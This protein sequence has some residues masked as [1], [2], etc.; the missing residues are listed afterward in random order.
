MS[1]LEFV[2]R[3]YSSGESSMKKRNLYVMTLAGLFAIAC[4]SVAA[5]FGGEEDG[6]YAAKLWQQ[7]AAGNLVGKYALYST[8]YKGAFPHGDYLDTIDAY[9]AVGEHQERLLMQR[10]YGG[11]G[12]TKAMV[13]NEPEKYL[14]AVT[15]MYK[16]EKGYDKENQD[17]FWVKYS[18]DGEVLKNP[19]GVVLAG[20]VAKGAKAGCIACHTAAPGGDMV[21]NNDR[22]RE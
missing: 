22:V 19:E 3:K 8:P 20:R 9:L 2:S 5:P 15:V 14:K 12:I 13:A 21:F 18:P 4:S 6:A 10:N 7:M 16:R 11:K 1:I 17:W